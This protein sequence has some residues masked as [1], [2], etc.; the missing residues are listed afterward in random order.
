MNYTPKA[1]FPGIV[2]GVLAIV[3]LTG[4]IS[5]PVEANTTS[6]IT[7][8]EELGQPEQTASDC[9]LATSYPDSIRQW[10]SLIQSYATENGLEPDLVAAVMLQESGG[11]AQ[12][13]S[14]SGAVGLM[15]V[16]PRDG[17][18]AGFT[19]PNGPC[20]ANRPSMDELF[21]PEFNIAYGTTMLAG[22]VGKY[23]NVRDALKA[24]GP[25]GVGYYYADIVLG[26]YERYR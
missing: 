8:I 4:M 19:C 1:L 15:Q 18:A 24:Y 7:V 21:V 26:I 6:P 23:G 2:I 25:M 20:F 16:M 14:K 3:F 5:S 22:L 9:T 12:A 17:I 10:C 13:Y 11:S